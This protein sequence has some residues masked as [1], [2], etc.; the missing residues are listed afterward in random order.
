MQ[1]DG[2]W[3]NHSKP[4]IATTSVSRPV[5]VG[6]PVTNSA[7]CPLTVGDYG[8]PTTTLKAGPY[9]KDL[10]IAT[11]RTFLKTAGTTDQPVITEK[12][13][14]EELVTFTSIAES[15]LETSLVSDA[16]SPLDDSDLDETYNSTKQAG[17]D[18]KL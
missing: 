17:G 4:G 11:P 5:T 7:S 12:L 2:A 6:D 9:V 14:C 16:E 18:Y 10:A 13:C 15:D 1:P 8:R 3:W